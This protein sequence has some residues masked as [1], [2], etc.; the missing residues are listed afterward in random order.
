VLRYSD[1]YVRVLTEK[2]LT[3]ALGRG[4]EYPICPWFDP[5]CTARLEQ[6]SIFVVGDGH[7]EERAV[8]YEEP[9][10]STGG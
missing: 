2:M 1:Q 8:P 10:R 6:L 7:R 4:V 5:S 3:Y 9:S